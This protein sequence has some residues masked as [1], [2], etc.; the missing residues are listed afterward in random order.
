MKSRITC[1]RVLEREPVRDELARH[2]QGQHLCRESNCLESWMEVS[3]GLAI[4]HSM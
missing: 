1:D 4:T 3:A 2:F